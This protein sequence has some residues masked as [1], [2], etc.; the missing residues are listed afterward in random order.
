[1]LIEKA[2]VNRSTY[3]YYFQNKENL[4]ENIIDN[5]LE[6][7]FTILQVELSEDTIKRGKEYHSMNMAL[8]EIKAAC[9]QIKKYEYLYKQWLNESTFIHKFTNALF[10]Y[11][12]SYSRD[13][14]YST[15]IAYGTIGYF[16]SWLHQQP[17]KSIEEI[18]WEIT[19]MAG[20]FFFDFSI[21]VQN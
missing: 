11:L 14:T 12:Y 3:Y 20:R 5:V 13:Q 19:N 18:S 1:M 6:E 9:N 4:I 2:G 10:N 15:Y 17:Q 8:P 21:P 16:Q 7:F